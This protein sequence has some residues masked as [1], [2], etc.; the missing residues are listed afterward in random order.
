[1][2]DE[3]LDFIEDITKLGHAFRIRLADDETQETLDCLDLVARTRTTHLQLKLAALAALLS[4]EEG[5]ISDNLMAKIDQLVAT[6]EQSLLAFSRFSPQMPTDDW[7]EK[8][9]ASSKQMVTAL[10]VDLTQLLERDFRFVTDSNAALADIEARLAAC[11]HTYHDSLANLDSTLRQRLDPEDSLRYRTI[12][13]TLADLRTHHLTL[14]LA[15]ADTIIDRDSGAI[16]AQVVSVIDD[17]ISSLADERNTLAALIHE[18]P[19]QEVVHQLAPQIQS[20]ASGIRNDLAQLI[21]RATVA[22]Q[23]A[24]EAFAAIDQEIGT[25]R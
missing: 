8:L 25:T 10:R 7:N 23:Q 5:N 21:T 24:D 9:N 11:R 19:E 17:E 16:D 6:R 14:M 13:G 15:A 20:L 18:S 22:N 2:N 4:R 12:L 3:L 1:M